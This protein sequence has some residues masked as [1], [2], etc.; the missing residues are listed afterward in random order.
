MSGYQNNEQPQNIPLGDVDIKLPEPESDGVDGEIIILGRDDGGSYMR[1]YGDNPNIKPM[2]IP[3][4][5]PAMHEIEE[6][7]MI[8]DV[9]VRDEHINEGEYKLKTDRLR[10]I[11]LKLN[12]EEEEEEEEESDEGVDA[13]LVTLTQ[14]NRVEW[15]AGWG[16][17]QGEEREGPHG[18]AIPSMIAVNHEVVDG[19]RSIIYD[20]ETEY[21]FV[22]IY[23]NVNDGTIGW[24]MYWNQE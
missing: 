19:Y 2:Q 21:E 5:A 8:L 4:H 20:P 24:D 3:G 23:Y 16:C 7:M 6:Y 22:H 1:Y 13:Y 14:Q 12:E 9:L 17:A 11:W 10:R 18:D 15:A